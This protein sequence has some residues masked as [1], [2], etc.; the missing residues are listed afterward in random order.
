MTRASWHSRHCSVV[1]VSPGRSITRTD[2]IPSTHEHTPASR[3]RSAGYHR[4]VDSPSAIRPSL[5]GPF[6]RVERDTVRRYGGAMRRPVI[7]QQQLAHMTT[8]VV[9]VRRAHDDRREVEHEPQ[10]APITSVMR[11]VRPAVRH[12]QAPANQR[13]NQYARCTTLNIIAIIGA[14]FS[15]RASWPRSGAPL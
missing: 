9:A 4:D 14:P 15:S 6:G 3:L 8:I 5:L 11:R 7:A 2:A 13:A 10:P 1:V 12:G